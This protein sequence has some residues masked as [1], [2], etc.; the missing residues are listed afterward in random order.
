MPLCLALGG[1]QRGVPKRV[2]GVVSGASGLTAYKVGLSGPRSTDGGHAGCCTQTAGRWGPAPH[3]E[4]L[5]TVDAGPAPAVGSPGLVVPGTIGLH[6]QEWGW[7]GS[8]PC[9]RHVWTPATCWAGET[10]VSKVGQ[11]LS[12]SQGHWR[13]RSVQGLWGRG[14]AVL[15]LLYWRGLVSK[16]AV[17]SLAVG[18]SFLGRVKLCRGRGNKVRIEK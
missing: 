1:A 15:Q 10:L 13:P 2:P 5:P 7:P 3:T 16:E 17:G 18:H 9:T 14:R 6:S 11:G 4:P 12:C 8:Q